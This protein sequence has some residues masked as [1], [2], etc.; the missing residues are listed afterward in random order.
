MYV[1]TMENLRNLNTHLIIEISSVLYSAHMIP[2]D[3]DMFVF[4]V[5]NHID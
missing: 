4:Y 2:R 5:N 3:Q 1:L